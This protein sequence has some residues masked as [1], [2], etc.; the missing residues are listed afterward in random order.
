MTHYITTTQL[1][2]AS[3]V[4]RSIMADRLLAAGLYTNTHTAT[5][6]AVRK[7]ICHLQQT[8]DNH[9]LTLWH[10][11]KADAWL[12]TH[13]PHEDGHSAI[14]QPVRPI[15]KNT[16]SFSCS[17]VMRFL[18]T[19]KAIWNALSREFT[20]TVDACASD[21]NHLLPR[22]WTEHDDGLQHDW[23][24][25]TVYCHPM[26]DLHIGKWVAKAAQ[27]RCTTVML[28]PAAT[29]TRYFHRHIYHNPRCEVRFL[30]K[31]T[32]GF[33]FGPDDGTADDPKRLGYIRPLMIVIF[34]NNDSSPAP[35]PIPTGKTG[36]TLCQPYITTTQL[37]AASG[38]SRSIMVNRLLAAG[39]CTNTHTVTK[40]AVR[41]DI[42]RLR[43]T[44]GTHV[45]TLWHREKTSVWLAAHRHSE[46]GRDEIAQQAEPTGSSVSAETVA[47][48]PAHI[49][50][51][52]THDEYLE[53]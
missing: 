23:T 19:P 27:S 6:Q 17:K 49:H 2:A 9:V 18:R 4:S 14:A 37:A 20:F 40:Q 42:C 50:I 34:R 41:N 47:G 32:R 8:W 13:A 11:E 1:A 48:L 29:H 21:A 43:R 7:G 5:K 31:P 15:A 44:W 45:L 35:R 52:C 24:G 28:I 39:L 10:P 36:T 22:Y 53:S 33:R 3:G 25:E 30:E 12:A 38:V 51:D 46:N 26:F 16:L